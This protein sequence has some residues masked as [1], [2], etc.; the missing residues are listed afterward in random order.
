MARRFLLTGCVT[1]LASAAL[2]ACSGASKPVATPATATTSGSVAATAGPTGDPTRGPTGSAASGGNPSAAT[3]HMCTAAH[4]AISATGRSAAAGHWS[5]VVLLRNTG[6]STCRMQ[7]YPG[8]DGLDENGNRGGGARQTPSGYMGG[9]T[10]TGDLP[11][12]DLA[13]GT[14]ASALVEGA[15]VPSG[16][17]PCQNY[18]GLLVTS[19]DGDTWTK[20]EGPFA[21]CDGLQV[22]PVVPGTSGRRTP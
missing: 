19:P 2:A 1:A 4:T 3:V 12:V 16:E 21:A 8:V 10:E 6:S 14:T 18:Q 22:H 7:G 20:L 17:V 9:L 15:S 13:P 11:V 5:L